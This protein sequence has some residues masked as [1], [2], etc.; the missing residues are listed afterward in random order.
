MR[1]SLTPLPALV[2][3]LLLLMAGTSYSKN[4]LPKTSKPKKTTIVKQEEFSTIK[5][6]VATPP[7]ESKDKTTII[8]E[9]WPEQPP[10]F[11]PAEPAVGEQLNWMVLSQGG[12]TQSSSTNY[13]LGVTIGQT[14]AGMSGSTN[15]N[16]NLGFWQNFATGC[17]V[18]RGDVN[19]LDG[20]SGP[21]DV[22]DITYLVAKLW[23]GGPEP[24]CEEEG[25]VNDMDGPGGPVDVADLTYLIA[26][27]WQGGPAPPAC[28]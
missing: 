12:V 7:K 15:Y 9:V 2:P 13:K 26:F 19:G 11:S 10:Q 20:P 18:N 1:R 14:A 21:I 17:C 28:D 5:P 23:Q 3:I 6:A 16:L 4:S 8:E 22:A 25:N 27:I 24:P